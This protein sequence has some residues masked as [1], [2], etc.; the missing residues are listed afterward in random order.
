MTAIAGS[1]ATTTFAQDP[2]ADQQAVY[3]KFLDNRKPCID[4]QKPDIEKCKVT[5]AAGEEYLQKYGSDPNNGEIVSSEEI[6]G[7][8]RWS[9]DRQRVKVVV[10]VQPAIAS[11]RCNCGQ[12]PSKVQR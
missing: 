7:R 5:I 2:A 12:K 9:I 10:R 4:K 3:Q 6:L 1:A 8:T 11:P